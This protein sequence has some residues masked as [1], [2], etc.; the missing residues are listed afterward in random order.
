M[1]SLDLLLYLFIACHAGMSFEKS[2][3]SSVL[4]DGRSSESFEKEVL[5]SISAAAAGTA[6]KK[7][8]D[9]YNSGLQIPKI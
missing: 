1:P 4:I 8:N 5:N 3:I 6:E 7:G 9:L 2:I